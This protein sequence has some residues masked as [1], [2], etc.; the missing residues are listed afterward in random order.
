MMPFAG[1]GSDFG[2]GKPPMGPVK[3]RS[4]SRERKPGDM[5]FNT[6]GRENRR[7]KD[8]QRSH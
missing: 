4:L 8:L 7:P 2:R 5:S 6:L 3:K 1:T